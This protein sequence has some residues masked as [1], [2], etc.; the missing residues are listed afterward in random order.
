MPQPSWR[1]S[2]KI[3]IHLINA[4]NLLAKPAILALALNDI[5]SNRTEPAR[6]NLFSAGPDDPIVILK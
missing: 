1:A 2:P 5:L 6:L 4:V 3:P